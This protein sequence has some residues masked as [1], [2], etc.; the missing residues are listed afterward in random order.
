MTDLPPANTW[1]P[2][3]PCS[4]DGSNNPSI[5]YSI[6]LTGVPAT[7]GAAAGGGYVWSLTLND[8]GAPPNF[9]I[10]H[11]DG[12]GTLIDHPIVVSGD[13]GSTTFNDPVYLSRDPLAPLEAATKEYVDANSLTGQEPPSGMGVYGRSNVGAGSWTNLAPPALAYLPLA[14][15]YLSGGVG[16]N[17]PTTQRFIGGVTPAPG[18]LWRWGLTLGDNTAES[19]SNNGS[20]F[21][22]TSYSDAGSGPTAQLTITRTGTAT[23]SQT[24]IFPS[25]V[26]V[27]GRLVLASPANLQIGGGTSGD[28]LIT[29]GFGNLIWGAGGSGGGVP[30]APLTGGPYGRQAANWVTIPPPVIPT[31]APSNASTYGR[32]G[33]AWVVVPPQAISADAPAISQLYGRYNNGWV[34]VGSQF[35]ALTGG[36]MTGG[37]VFNGTGSARAIAGQSAGV[38]RWVEYI[39]DATAETGGNSGSNFS[40]VRYSDAG[41][42]IDTPLS[43]SRASG[44][45]SMPDGAT[46]PTASPGD[47]SNLAASTAFVGAAVAAAGGAF[48]HKSG[49]TMTGNLAAPSLSAANG[50]SAPVAAASP[51]AA[52]NSL[53]LATTAWVNQAVNAAQFGGFNNR[54][55]NGTFDIWQR[56]SPISCP[57]GVATYTADG[58][59]VS[60]GGA[61]V[62]AQTGARIGRSLNSHQISGAAGVTSA[63]FLQ[64]I[65]SSVC[66]PLAGQICTF[67]ATIQNNASGSITPQLDTA[68]P[69]VA[70]NFSANTAD[71]G[72]VSL[73]PIASGAT[74]KV[75]YTFVVSASAFTGYQVRLA[76][77][78]LTSGNVRIS[79]CDIRVTPG[80][81]GGLNANPPPPELRPVA[82]ELAFC[83]RYY[84]VGTL[85]GQVYQVA[86]GG[87]WIGASFPVTMRA[88]PT[89]ATITNSNVNLSGYALA[90]NSASVR[91][92]GT[93]TATGSVQV[94]VAW[95]ANIEL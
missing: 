15:G 7:V 66:A 28:T 33:G 82:I 72:P 78:A 40:L 77:G 38:M 24:C 79:D 75:A 22:L 51:L 84:Q 19:G 95:T 17:G 12:S 42:I 32:S 91:N 37:L 86:A 76:F 73:Q 44:L 81:P 90:S 94:N 27:N 69:T 39:A 11:Y 21:V 9:T 23:F 41:A 60:P 35:L 30:E 74:V 36:A 55:R 6:T 49:D 92:A 59:M 3:E 16:F 61:A 56:G 54:F 2:A 10:D 52:D 53:N 1:T 71:L 25:Q 8:G 87:V 31:D 68:Y 83:Q 14:G 4:S 63:N 93:A 80:A 20:N 88:A 47:S 62:T 18:N 46:V 50:T 85:I 89:M 58:W 29:D 57:S 5:V 43:I 65:E 26:I 13:D 48:V 70:D 64:R 34:Q 67:Q 45:V